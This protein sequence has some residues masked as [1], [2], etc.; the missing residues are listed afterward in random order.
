[1]TCRISKYQTTWLQ[2]EERTFIVGIE[3]P[4]I[5]TRERFMNN[6]KGD[7]KFVKRTRLRF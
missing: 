1:M 6:F 3:P 2:A 5:I 4:E 7:C